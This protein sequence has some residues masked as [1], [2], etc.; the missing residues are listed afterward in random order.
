MSIVG[1]MYISKLPS[2][3]DSIIS[4]PFSWEK[5]AMQQLSQRFPGSGMRNE[6]TARDSQNTF[7]RLV[8]NWVTLSPCFGLNRGFIVSKPYSMAFYLKAIIILKPNDLP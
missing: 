3:Q 8:Q 5:W 4:T 7:R 6:S 1:G 2:A